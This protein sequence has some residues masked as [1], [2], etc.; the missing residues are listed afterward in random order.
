MEKKA[1]YDIWIDGKKTTVCEPF[2]FDITEDEIVIKDD[3]SA[4]TDMK[5][6]VTGHVV[7]L[8]W[9]ERLLNWIKRLW[10]G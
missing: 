8:K 10:Q 3:L 7:K 1:K 2:S 6:E 5:I 9:Y 4:L